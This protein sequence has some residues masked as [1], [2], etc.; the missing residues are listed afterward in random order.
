MYTPGYGTR[1]KGANWFARKRERHT[2]SNNTPAPISSESWNSVNKA[3]FYS[4]KLQVKIHSLLECVLCSVHFGINFSRLKCEHEKK[5]T[6][7][8]ICNI[9]QVKYKPLLHQLKS[10]K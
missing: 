7:I 3:Y 5:Q 1:G 8:T 2:H 9:E 6:V 10:A 4:M